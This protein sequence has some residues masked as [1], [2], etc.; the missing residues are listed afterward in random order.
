VVGADLF[1]YE[2]IGSVYPNHYKNCIFEKFVSQMEN[3]YYNCYVSYSHGK[4]SELKSQ[5]NK[6][7]K[8]AS[9]ASSSRFCYL[10]L[11]TGAELLGGSGNVVFEHECPI[12]GVK[13]TAPQMDAYI[14][15]ENMFVE[16]KCHEIFDV[17]KTALSKQYFELLFGKTN[18]FGFDYIPKENMSDYE[19]D[20]KSNEFEIPFKKMGI[21][22]PEM[23]DV[24]QFI[25]HLLGVRCHKKQDE[26]AT[27]VYLF[28]KPKVATET[29]Q[30]EIDAIFKKLALE[31]KTLFNNNAVENFI[32]KN[33]I[34]LKAVAEY[35]EVMSPLTSENIIYLYP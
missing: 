30:N 10:A 20:E 8:M 22:Q 26:K 24:K 25:C 4:G 28:F 33:N 1:G 31:I 6:P 35:S 11:R 7:P 19:I 17:H 21:Q 27:L 12:D 16:V 23:L 14:E 2:K 29:E 5:G 3:N 34:T 18:D 32:K 9:V 13:G 15:K